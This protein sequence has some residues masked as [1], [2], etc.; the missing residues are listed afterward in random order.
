MNWIPLTKEEQIAE[1]VERSKQVPCLVF[2]H[3]TRCS[4]SSIAKHRLEDDWSFTPEEIVPYY[5]D[6]ISYR[7]LSSKIAEDFQVHHESPQ[8][9]LIVD[10]E[11]IYDASHLDIS[12]AELKEVLP[13]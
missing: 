4:I 13:A 10:G 11:C 5:L 8:V 9:L 1:L 2:K 12:V 7:P 6:L 3:S